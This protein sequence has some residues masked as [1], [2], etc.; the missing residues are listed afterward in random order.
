MKTKDI[1]ITCVL[2][3]IVIVL[4][5]IDRNMDTDI[6]YATKAYQ[7]YLDGEVVGLIEDDQELYDLIDSEQQE[8]KINMMLIM[9]IHLMLLKLSK[10]ILIVKIIIRHQIYMI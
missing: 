5:F 1:I 2:S 7:V 9:Y 4:Y 6:N 3:V 10:L 8:I